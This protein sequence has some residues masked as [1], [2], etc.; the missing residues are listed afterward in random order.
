MKGKQS[1]FCCEGITS[2]CMLR[3]MSIK[4]RKS[5]INGMLTKDEGG[6]TCFWPQSAGAGATETSRR[7]F[8]LKAVY[9]LERKTDSWSL[10]VR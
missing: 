10:K 8:V 6:K 2:E 5:N 3:R 7:C 1:T 4:R 9:G